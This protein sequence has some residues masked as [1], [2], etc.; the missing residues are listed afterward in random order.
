[1]KRSLS[2]ILT[3][4]MVLTFA[5]PASGLEGYDKELENA[6]VK[7]KSV[8]NITDEFDKFEYHINSY[9]S[10]LE[11]YLRWYDSTEKTGGI[12]V[13]IDT[14]GM[15]KSYYKYNY[16][17]ERNENALPNISKEEGL[18]I[19]NNFLKKVVPELVDKVMYVESNEPLNVYDRVYYF[20]YY[21]IENGIP[22]YQNN[23]YVNVD[24]MTG[25]V[26]SFNCYW[27]K[28]IKFD[29]K[30]GI[31]G[32]K[33]AQKAYADKIG[34][35]LV[36]KLDYSDRQVTP[37]VVYTSLYSEKSIDAKTGEAVSFNDYIRYGDEI[38]TKEMAADNS[39]SGATLTPEELEAISKAKD[40]ISKEEAEK[41]ARQ[42]LQ[43]SDEYKISN[44]N[45]YSVWNEKDSFIWNMYFTN[46]DES[47]IS[48]SID[49]KNKEF[50]SFYKYI[51]YEEKAE[52]KYNREQLQKK[53]EEFI[54][55]V[56]KDKFNSVELMDISEPII[57]PLS[58]EMP[59]QQYFTFTRKVGDAYFQ[60][61]GFNLNVNAIT[62]EI[63]SYDYNWYK[64][65]LPSTAKAIG[66][67]K[68]YEIL[69]GRIGIEL[70][71]VKDNHVAYDEQEKEQNAKLV[72]TIKNDKP[73]NIDA[74]NGDLLYG[75]NRPYKDS[76]VSQYTDIEDSYAKI[77]IETLAKYGIGFAGD[78]FNPKANIKQKE[79][80]Y[81]LLKAKSYYYD[82]SDQD[83][84]F[85]EKL[86][87]YMI[88]E[89]IVKE[90]EKSPES[91]VT[92]EEVAKYIVRALGY[93][94]VAN[95]EGIYKLSFKDANKVSSEFMGYVA[96]A[97]GLG[98]IE[99]EGNNLNPSANM[100][101]EQAAVVIYNLL[102]VE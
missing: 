28:N 47:S 62:G 45:L 9:S 33:D 91:I 102:D 78:K 41:T 48:I 27:D 5:I 11:F 63:I 94:K 53:A 6:I 79:F 29:S 59:R 75:L 4:L 26:Q 56:Q 70:Q 8:F 95:I 92:K 57:R 60:G 38:A 81:L 90:N 2:L 22:F 43:V 13:T 85:V 93:E 23:V 51:P 96:I 18:D 40:I 86:Y 32:L 74:F 72:Y 44:I 73:L 21:R 80:L 50:I 25:E 88:N 54:K 67:D 10:N 77:Q 98:I 46:K 1:M 87:K 36:Y 69:F 68:A 30:D 71:Y 35:K 7:A 34:L 20:N 17:V 84:G 97:T 83:K 58:E 66:L 64:G 89:K 12:E 37:Y 99:S 16:N 65:Q 14:D 100:T 15:I 61:N 39:V 19:A 42:I 82:I 49:A 3:L 101:R 31:I 52:V 55:K 24:N 76:T